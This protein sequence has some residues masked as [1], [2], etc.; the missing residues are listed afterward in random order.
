[1]PKKS[2]ETVRDKVRQERERA[3]SSEDRRRKL[4]KNAAEKPIDKK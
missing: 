4:Q 3:A 2:K 1:M